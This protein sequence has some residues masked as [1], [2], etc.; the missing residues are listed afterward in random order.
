MKPGDKRSRKAAWDEKNYRLL[1][2]VLGAPP[3]FYKLGFAPRTAAYVVH[4]KSRRL[5]AV[6]KP[7]PTFNNF[8]LYP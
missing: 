4:V 2:N 1:S 5:N 6:P 3:N 8:G 7:A